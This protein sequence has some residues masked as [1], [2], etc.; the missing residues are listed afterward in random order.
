M[1]G[2]A[3]GYIASAQTI[4]TGMVVDENDQP[5]IGATVVVP[6]TTQGTTTDVGGNF[7]FGCVVLRLFR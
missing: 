5:L 7:R 2:L 1:F 4:V 6:E 3:V